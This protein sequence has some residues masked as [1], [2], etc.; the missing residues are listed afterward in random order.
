MHFIIENRAD[1]I[2]ENRGIDGAVIQADDIFVLPRNSSINL[3]VLC[4]MH[5]YVQINPENSYL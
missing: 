3:C 2:I 4:I 1:F 5:I